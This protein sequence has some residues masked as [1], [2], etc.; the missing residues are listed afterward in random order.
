MTTFRPDQD[1]LYEILGVD[2]HASAAEIKKAYRKLAQLHHPDANAGDKASEERFKKINA[3]YDVLSD[4]KKR[5]DYD[6]MRRL[7]S[8]GGFRPGASGGFSGGGI[9]F[10]DLSDLFGSAGIR[11]EDIF[12]G[13][14]SRRRGPGRRRGRDVEASLHLTFEDAMNGVTTQVRIPAHEP[15]DR[16]DGSGAEPGTE[17]LPCPACGGRGTVSDQ[18]GYFGLS[19]PCARCG[20]EGQVIDHPCRSCRGEGQIRRSRDVKVAIPA[21][22]KDGTRVRVRG[23][24]EPGTHG[25]PPGDLFVQTH[26][27]PHP[28]FTRKGDDL[29][30]TTKVPYPTLVLGGEA[31]VQTLDGSVTLKVGEGTPARRTLRVKGKGAP[32]SKGKGRGDLLVTLDVDIPRKLSSEAREALLTYA[33][34]TGAPEDAGDTPA[35][36]DGDEG[37]G[38]G[39]LGRKKKAGRKR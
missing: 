37:K 14:E 28:V 38:H 20:G 32:R 5:K 11:F 39:R 24:G 13:G 26:V 36:A 2:P 4:E 31:K 30:M 35:D 27:S 8:S 6:E 15:C 9:R 7:I 25:G 34:V 23:R 16:C 22:V 21:G 29:A 33:D 17:P 19:R 10:E 1:D 12:G 18:Q 3:A